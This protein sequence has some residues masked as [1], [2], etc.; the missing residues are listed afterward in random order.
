MK[1]IKNIWFF[2]WGHILGAVFY[3]KQYLTGDA[4]KFGGLGWWWIC[5][6]F[7]SQKI[8]GHNRAAGWPVSRNIRINNP[9]TICF[10]NEDLSN[11]HSFGIYYQSSDAQIVI[12]KGTRIGPNVGLIT[13]NHDPLDLNKH[14]PAKPI[15]LGKACWIGMNAVILPGVTLGDHTIVGAGAIVTHSYPQGNCIIA[16]NP[17]KVVKELNR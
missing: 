2:V 7:F 16:G 6:C 15:V 8:C 13:K 9:S 10:D 4:Y 1:R 17:A 3:K 14:L 12:G 5:K 11:F